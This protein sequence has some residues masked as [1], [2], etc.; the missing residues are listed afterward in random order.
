MKLFCGEKERKETILSF[1]QQ[2]QQKY[3]FTTSLLMKAVKVM[4]CTD[5]VLTD[6][7]MDVHW[8]DY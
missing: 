1:Q 5:G 7:Q 8:D 6:A 3:F 4:L 2:Q